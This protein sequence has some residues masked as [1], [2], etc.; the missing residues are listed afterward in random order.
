VAFTVSTPTSDAAWRPD[1]FAFAPGD[2]LP[3]ALVLQTSTV[4][5]DIEGDEPSVRVAF[6][7]DDTAK[8]YAEGDPLDEAQPTLAEALIH[9]SKAAMLVR[10]TTEQ[11]LQPQTPNQLSQS[12]ARAVQRTADAAFV[13]QAAPIGPAVAPSAGLLNWPGVVNGG[14]V[15]DS[16]DAIIELIADL[17]SHLATPSHIVIGPKAWAALRTFKV[18]ST[19]NQSLLGAGTQDAVPRLLGLPLIVTNALADSYAGLIVDRSAIV[20]AVG[21]VKVSTSEHTYF[22]NDSVALRCTWRFGHTVPRPNRIGKFTIA[23]GGS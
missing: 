21:P 17:E 19:Y 22:A 18:G 5:G 9:T 6:I 12:V 3:E 7:T 1:H 16:L 10:I 4:A 11:Y 20:S 15:S 23:G 2:I 14:T 8:F 13:S